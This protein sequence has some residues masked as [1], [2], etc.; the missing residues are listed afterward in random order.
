MRDATGW[1]GRVLGPSLTA[2]FVASVRA[3]YSELPAPYGVAPDPAA[4][5]LLPGLFALPA[6]AARRAS[7]PTARVMHV[8]LGTAF[9]GL[10]YHVA[11]RTYAIDRA[12]REATNRGVKQVVLLG[13]GLDNRA[14]RL[15]ELAH[16]T[17]FEV[18]HHATQA[19]KTQML[20]RA[21]WS[22][23]DNVRLVGV[24]FERGSLDEA[25]LRAGLSRSEP[26]FWVWEGVS[27]YLTKDAIRTTL[28]ATARCS[29]PGS[30]LA[31]T[32]TPPGT[33]GPLL[34]QAARWMT[35]IIQEPIL[36]S[37]SQDELRTELERA[38]FALVSDE[39]DSDWATQVWPRVPPGIR[40]W[41]R[42][43]VAERTERP[44]AG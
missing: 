37:I 41:E 13:A 26:T 2:T 34:W 19:Y 20:A 28:A 35:R 18:D 32:Y 27:I 1:L 38:G 7:G 5:A 14:L 39:A 8:G 3:Y 4:S 21:G 12:L 6:R 15:R 25:L 36:G 17:V 24:D 29:A 16:H 23:A 43:A 22:R 44:L 10:T 11:L 33:G 42:L 30:R 9:L 40:E 31:M